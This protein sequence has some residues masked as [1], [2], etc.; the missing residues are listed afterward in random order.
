[1]SNA[2]SE[3]KVSFESSRD[4]LAGEDTGTDMLLGGV[5]FCQGVKDKH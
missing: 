4:R 3:N 5:L 1:M 2:T